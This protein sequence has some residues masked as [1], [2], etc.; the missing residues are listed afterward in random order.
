MGPRDRTRL[1]E[2]LEHVRETERRIQQAEQQ[3]GRDLTIPAAPIGVPESFEDHA[4]LMFDLLAIAFETDQT[5]VFTFMMCREFSVRTYPNLGV[6]DPHHT[7]SHTQNRPALIAAHTKVN[8]YHVQLFGKFLDAPARDAGRRWHAAR[9]LDDSLRQRYGRRECPR[10]LSAS[11][12]DRRW[13]PRCKGG[14]HLVTPEKTPLPNLLLATRASVRRGY[15]RVSA[16]AREP[17]A[18]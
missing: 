18:L 5:R 11:D 2:Y 3:A 1:D 6:T 16:S 17:I 7:V 13:K 14:R 4:S 12:G 8:T 15:F 9:S 10:A